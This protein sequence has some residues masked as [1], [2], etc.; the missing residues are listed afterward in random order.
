MRKSA[1][2]NSKKQNKK[3]NN[4]IRIACITSALAA[5]SSSIYAAVVGNNTLPTGQN[6]LHG[7]VTITTPSNN[8]MN[9]V[10]NE[11]NAVIKWDDFSIG[12]NAEVNF[13]R[14]NGG[15]FNVLNYVDSGKVSQIY[16][17]INAKDGNVFVVNTAGAIIGKSAQI[18]VGSLYVSNK[19][20]NDGELEAFYNGGD[21]PTINGF[22]TG[23][24]IMS[25]G[26]INANKVTFDGD[27]IVLDINRLVTNGEQMNAR[28]IIVNTSDKDNKDNIVLGYD[29]YDEEKGYEY[30]DKN[31][32]TTVI[33]TV[34]G[35]GFTKEN[36]Y[37]WVKTLDQLQEMKTNLK[38][39]YALNDSIDAIPTNK[40]NDGKG[41]ES[42]GKEGNPF[43][44]K[45]DGL[46]Y[47]I[48]GLTINRNEEDNVGL[49]G[50]TEGATINNVTLVSGNII[51][52]D[53]VGS[54]V[55]Y[56]KNTNISNVT[57]SVEVSGNS[58]V[59]GVVGNFESEDGSNELKNIVNI[60]VTKGYA[61]VG[62]IAGNMNGGKLTGQSYNLGAVTG[63]GKEDENIQLND[64]SH[65]IGGLVGSAANV[66]L[67]DGETQ[68][69]NQLNI[70][71]GYN[72]GGIVGRINDEGDKEASSIN[73]AVNNGNVLA[74][75]YTMGSYK[76]QT[77]NQEMLGRPSSN[78]DPIYGEKKEEVRIAN[79]GGI[80]GS[81]EGNKDNGKITIENVQ[82][83]GD[84][85]TKSEEGRNEGNTDVTYDYYIAGNVGGVVGSANNVNITDAKNVEN[86]I[87]GAHNVGG[88]AGYFE[89][90][91]I[92]K[93]LND[94]GDIMGTGARN[95]NGWVI[96][97]LRS[98]VTNEAGSNEK[99]RVGNI[100][101]IVGYLY[102][103]EKEQTTVSNSGNRGNVHSDKVSGNI[104]NEDDIADSAKAS[105]VGGIVGKINARTKSNLDDIKMNP[106]NASVSNSYNTG[107]VQGYTGIGGIAG[108]MWNGAVTYSY[109]LGNII[110]SRKAKDDASGGKNTALN[111]GGIV[112]DTTEQTH[113]RAVI[114][115]VFNKGTIGDPDFILSGR[116][117]GGIVGRL[118]G[119]VDTSFNNGNIYNSHS[120]VGGIAGYF[121]SGGISNVFNTGN[122]VVNRSPGGVG[123]WVGGLV[124]QASGYFVGEEQKQLSIEN[125]YNLGVVRGQKYVAGIIAGT[126]NQS[127][128]DPEMGWTLSLKNVYTTG[129]I[130][131]DND[132]GYIIS[133]NH[134]KVTIE[135]D[136][137][138]Y[139]EPD[140]IFSYLH[141]LKK[142]NL[143][144]G[145]KFDADSN[146][147]ESWQ[148]FIGES[149]EDTWRIYDGTTPIL[150]VFKPGTMTS[151]Y[152][153]N[154]KY[155]D[156]GKFSDDV[157]YGTA[158]DPFLT[159]IN[160]KND[161]DNINVNWSDAGFGI[162]EGLVVNGAGVSITNFGQ[163]TGSTVIKDVLPYGG[164][165][166]SDGLTSISSSD[167]NNI[168]LGSAAKIYGSAVDI[169]STGDL[170]INGLV[171]STGNNETLKNNGDVALSGNNVT[172]YGEIKSAQKDENI[173]INGIEKEYIEPLYS[174][175]EG[176][177]ID[178]DTYLVKY[179]AEHL[180]RY[181]DEIADYVKKKENEMP[182][183]SDYLAKT[184][185][186][187]ADGDITITA[188][189]DN[190]G[191]FIDNGNVKVLFGN[192]ETG[193][194][195]A[196]D[197][198]TVSGN[199]VYMDS[200]LL[201][202][203][204]LTI[205]GNTSV[206]DI[207]NIGKVQ[208]DKGLID[209]GLI[210]K[211]LG[212]KGKDLTD[213]E[214]ALIGL[215]KFLDHFQGDSDSN[216]ITM[217]GSNEEVPSDAMIT[218]DLWG[219]GAFDLRKFDLSEGLAEILDKE[220]H[221]LSE[222][223]QKLNLTIN[224]TGNDNGNASRNYVH[225]WVSD[226]EQ[227]KGIQ[228]QVSELAK[229]DQDQSKVQGFLEGNFALKND[230]DAS[231][232]E[233]YESIGKGV[234]GGF[235]G[236]FDG[237]G[238]RII[239]L[240]VEDGAG[241]FNKVGEGGSVDDVK[242]YS[243]NVSGAGNV[244]MVAG[245]NSG[246]ITN[247]TTF[248]NSVAV[249]G[250]GD[251]VA[252][253]ASGM[254]GGIV[255]TNNGS[256]TNVSSTSI[257]ESISK[258]GAFHL[259]GIAG[260]NEGAASIKNSESNSALTITAGSSQNTGS[261]GGIVGT[262]KGKLNQV[263]SSGIISGLYKHRGNDKE[264][265]HVAS[266][267][268]GIAGI[269][270]G[271]II[272]AYNDSI[273]AGML[274]VGGVVG[275]NTGE[276]TNIANAT[277]VYGGENVGGIVGYNDGTITD[278]RNNGAIFGA[279]G[280]EADK[281]IY[282]D[283]D[284]DKKFTV[285]TSTGKNIG[286]LVGYSGT[287]GKM[288]NL[289]NDMSASITGYENVGGIIGENHGVLTDSQN[290]MNKGTISGVTDVGGIIGENYGI[291]ANIN[292]QNTFDIVINK[293]YGSF[294][295]GYKYFGGIVG[296]NVKDDNE[297]GIVYNVSNSGNVKVEGAQFVGGVIGQN[298][299]IVLGTLA[300]SGTVQGESNVGG[301]IGINNN[302]IDAASVESKNA[303]TYLDNKGIKVDNGKVVLI[304]GA[305]VKVD[306]NGQAKFTEFVLH[307]N[308]VEGQNN[309]GGVIGEKKG[310]ITNSDVINSVVAKVQGGNNVGGIIGV[311][312]GNVEGSRDQED[313]YYANHVYNNGSVSGGENIGGLIGSNEKDSKLEA[314][315]NTGTVEGKANVGGIAGTNSGTISQ[316]FNNV[317]IGNPDN[318]QNYTVGSVE[319]Y[320]NVGGLVGVNDGKLQYAY[321]S[322]NVSIQTN[323]GNIVGT[324]GE[325]GVI[326]GVYDA[327]NTNGTFAGQNL[328]V[329]SNSYSVSQYDKN[330]G[331]T[332]LS[333]EKAK[334]SDYYEDGFWEKDENGENKTWK[335]YDGLTNPLLKVFLTKATYEGFDGTFN[336]DN[337]KG[338]DGNN[339]FD[340][341]D[342]LVKVGEYKYNYYLYSQ[343]IIGSYYEDGNFNP[344][345]LGYDLD[346]VFS[347]P[348]QPSFWETEDKYAWT[349]D[350]KREDRERKAELHF[351]SGG[352]EL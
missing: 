197:N 157:Q 333:G 141:E 268:G 79:A 54:V 81:V 122:I 215:H 100:G 15:N 149:G 210:D 313:N 260:V 208:T 36:G 5:Y 163:K 68:I 248:G 351:V 168:F 33:A 315:Y 98:N 47:N 130:L 290:L 109:N 126:D 13:S 231:A 14:E 133:S 321:N 217:K 193:F 214:K 350:K 270:S 271:T 147:K 142:P 50:Y 343:Q 16:G 310:N 144:Y 82:N 116:H 282:R 22:V 258:S 45:F 173:V 236:K 243:S 279:K 51:G 278:G 332:V 339:A 78:R 225:I 337:F 3:I 110:S 289:V 61:S 49:F 232:V 273:V 184:V 31:N 252:E 67:G 56:A 239:G 53:N 207:S 328:G 134:N 21:N 300:N 305:K 296:H 250:T 188:N 251:S 128:K 63:I 186:S 10:Q 124:G 287:N 8:I 326:I 330:Q 12:A 349:W 123:S 325:R 233:M 199:D 242:I 170:I 151:D 322:S 335:F 194:V 230:I 316:V 285:F 101:G 40:W 38:G 80:A 294:N 227:L 158:Y 115:N 241:I 253:D 70:T 175:G 277:Y 28:N 114:Y 307:E 154:D 117:V 311:N 346:A 324:N 182:T 259:G 9:I 318:K 304:N 255:G 209:K 32:K 155:E 35:S 309:V 206:L 160:A 43:K 297:T 135:K 18:N 274:Y 24:E 293:A 238:N 348:K 165:I 131:A 286:G 177:N 240:N 263:S 152:F 121:V 261:I 219:N 89:N 254:A 275:K 25:L 150:N 143:S 203:G 106:E 298:D 119:Y 244:G 90:G 19:K 183:I 99:F 224:G 340:Q 107:K 176:D 46:D 223:L 159:I 185:R 212:D 92:D 88:I 102:D 218:V 229:D 59:G 69:F 20:M 75:G 291:V 145:D 204:N 190:E 71:G 245:T 302:N 192:E 216:T 4:L 222:D 156:Y 37:M 237:R 267:V 336:A 201:V 55:G 58:N 171:Q 93:A 220:M 87:R 347:A 96:E 111:M 26:N 179:I 334:D 161:V 249:S 118:S 129:N 284:I 308:T 320:T 64:Y 352:M 195:N 57:N 319:G 264:L 327:Y 52:G 338:E 292:N 196:G 108:S 180:G 189:K 172:V 205:N 317:M 11:Q 265:Y 169:N 30:T 60:G 234:E 29:A 105:N 95:E 83:N 113:A 295:D 174:Y 34:N 272:E 74:V 17:G 127:A 6:W 73:N 146:M 137:I 266:H 187:K 162:T 167:G 148:K 112:G 132:A 136:N 23:A 342:W 76:Y 91:K 280:I 2:I 178:E 104:S 341:N 66:Q 198:L 200:D 211:G 103:G 312:F 288:S 303:I 276:I 329:I 153:G 84:V 331:V 166:Y 86:N 247:I 281:E 314:A 62:G 283:D 72:V 77:S 1:K 181:S 345:N 323:G 164:I 301:I 120:I 85:K 191:K 262:N 269:N 97:T 257:V 41:F 140:G 27:R 138:C 39:N 235:T 42:I 65:D 94:G 125:A 48:F 344:N 7:Q 221:T 226:G 44:G 256:I 202:G 299:G 139:L 246:S 306:E 213:D 228:E